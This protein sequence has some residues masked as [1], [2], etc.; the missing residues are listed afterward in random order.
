[1][2]LDDIRESLTVTLNKKT[3][4]IIIYKKRINLITWIFLISLLI[5]IFTIKFVSTYSDRYFNYLSS[6][7][8]IKNFNSIIGI[9]YL[10][11][12]YYK[13]EITRYIFFNISLIGLIL[14]LLLIGKYHNKYDTLRKEII[15]SID[16][17]FCKHHESCSCKDDYI[18][19]MK[20]EHN[21]DLI[22]KWLILKKVTKTF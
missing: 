18:L 2:P 1:M 20:R 9:N 17:D 6:Y 4:R 21:I 12:K 14:S 22:F 19:A 15:N 16:S 7:G 13:F 11:I 3:D 8:F 10:R 5:F